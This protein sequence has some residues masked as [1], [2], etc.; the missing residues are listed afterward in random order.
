[1]AD[2]QQLTN[3]AWALTSLTELVLVFYLVNRGLY[4]SHPAF[5]FYI[6]AAI[7][8]SL[9]VALLYHAWDFRSRT[10]WWI[11]WGSQ[12]LLTGARWLAS[13]EIA[14]RML[15]GFPG[16]WGLAKRVLLVA[17]AIVLAYSLIFFQGNLQYKVMNME[18]GLKLAIACF[19]VLLFLFAR[20]YRVPVF[21]LERILAIGF[22]LYSCFSVI[23]F[24]LFEPLREKYS[25]LWNFLDILFFLATLVIWILAVRTFPVERLATSPVQLS[26]EYY[27]KL[28]G[29]INLRLRVLNDRLAQLLRSEDSHP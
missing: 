22:F 4:R 20:Y 1:M 16:I 29:Q 5:L 19:I 11:A 9:T 3:F 26:P 24:T 27:G 23:N 21:P 2:S 10:V 28:S 13:F 14:R 25:N 8:Q 7:F 6:S 15:S 18:R 12:L 17:S